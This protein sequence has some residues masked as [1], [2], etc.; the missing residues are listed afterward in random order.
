MNKLSLA[1]CV[2]LVGLGSAQ[3]DDPKAKSGQ[4][5]PPPP[6]PPRATSARRAGV[7]YSGPANGVPVQPRLY[8]QQPLPSAGASASTGLSKQ[9]QGN[10]MPS[11]IRHWRARLAD[12]GGAPVAQPTD[13][14]ITERT[15]RRMN[16]RDRVQD[17]SRDNVETKVVPASNANVNGFRKRGTPVVSFNNNSNVTFAV[18]C[19]RDH[20]HPHDRGWWRS[21]C[22]IVILVG[23][24]YFGFDNGWWYPAFGYDSYYSSYSYD[25]PVYGYDGLPPDQVIANVQ[26]A[27]Q[28]LGYFPYAVDGVLGPVTQ[29]AIADFQRDQGIYSTGAIDR[30]TLLA[31]GFID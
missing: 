6:P 18:A 3:A 15:G 24:G 16:D 26:G 11:Q 25:L 14:P 23:G 1:V 30:P 2:V 9:N 17:G 8:R 27:L 22:P 21:H 28:E 5:A 12:E 31:L 7:H 4:D 19:R 20:R 29:Q 13:R 10:A